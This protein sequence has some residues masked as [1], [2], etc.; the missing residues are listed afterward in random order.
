MRALGLEVGNL[1]FIAGLHAEVFRGPGAECDFIIGQREMG[2]PSGEEK[3]PSGGAAVKSMA[4]I[5][6]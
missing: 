1:N 2:W 5:V 6:E 4:V 3:G